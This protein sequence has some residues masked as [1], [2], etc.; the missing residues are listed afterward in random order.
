LERSI[1]FGWRWWHSSLPLLFVHVEA[2][3]EKGGEK[4]K[5]GREGGRERERGEIKN[6]SK[7]YL[8]ST[9]KE[10]YMKNMY[11]NIKIIKQTSLKQTKIRKQMVFVAQTKLLQN[12][13]AI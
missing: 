7:P 4:K 12:K 13:P 8:G 5:G 3:K 9:P 11:K 10:L 2:N 6:K 1:V